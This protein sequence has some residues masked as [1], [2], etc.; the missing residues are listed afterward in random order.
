M[1]KKIGCLGEGALTFKLVIALCFFVLAVCP[2][3]LAVPQSFS[4]NGRLTDELGTS[5]PGTSVINFSIYD[6]ATG[7]NI[8]WSSNRSV[9]TDSGGIYS[10]RLT[11]ID[12]NFTQQYYL[13]I[14]VGSDSEMTP[15]IN[16]SSS[17]YAI[18]A[19]T[20]TALDGWGNYTARKLNLFSGGGT[21]LNATDGTMT[22][23][24]VDGTY[25]LDVNFGNFT[26]AGTGTVASVGKICDSVG[27]IGDAI[28]GSG[29]WNRSGAVLIP[30]VSGDNITVGGEG[31]FGNTYYSILGN[32]GSYAGVFT[33]G[34]RGAYLADGSRA[35]YFYDGSRVAYLA[36]G[37]QAGQFYDGT[38]SAYFADGT[39]AGYFTDTSNSYDAY[40][41]ESSN[42]NAAGYFSYS[43][44]SMY[45]TLATSSVAGTFHDG[46]RGAYLADGSRAG[47]FYDGSREAYLA[48]GSQAG[49]FYDGSRVAYLADGSQA[50]YAYD[51]TRV[52][53][54]A[55]GSQAGQFHDGQRTVNLADGSY[56]YNDGSLMI[57][58]GPSLNTSGTKN[59]TITSGGGSVIIKLG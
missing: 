17:G 54:L 26:I 33:D 22:V 40:L 29:Y 30:S 12:M 13:G 4:I 56:S 35:G 23:E 28:A 3:V 34:T 36:D 19:N 8:L 50:L 59:L 45:A 18:R 43:G 6:A 47:Y 52:A 38:R 1:V 15:R 58:G 2:V 37:S 41:A 5:I 53:Y 31:K 21:A 48:D 49:Y 9:T 39:S 44:G 27:C 14:K 55:D 16:L 11:G 32:E 24:I 10:E 46:T 42:Y 57:G 7:G 20:T 25:A 51:G